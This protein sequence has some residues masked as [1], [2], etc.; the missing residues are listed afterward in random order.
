MRY[1]VYFEVGG[2]NYSCSLKYASVEIT[3]PIDQMRLRLKNKQKQLNP[4]EKMI[5]QR[6]IDAY[7]DAQNIELETVEEPGDSDKA[8]SN[9]VIIFII[10]IILGIIIAPILLTFAM[11]GKLLLKSTFKDILGFEE[12]KKFRKI[13]LALAYLWMV[14]CIVCFAVFSVLPIDVSN[15]TI[16]I[17]ALF[18]GNL[19]FVIIAVVKAKHIKKEYKEEVTRTLREDIDEKV[20]EYSTEEEVN[21]DPMEEAE[22]NQLSLE[23]VSEYIKNLDTLHKN[24]LINDDEY[25]KHKDFA[26]KAMLNSPEKPIPSSNVNKTPKP[27]PMQSASIKSNSVVIEES[28]KI[29]NDSDSPEKTRSLKTRKVVLGS[30]SLVLL[31]P[32]PVLSCI[33]P[34]VFCGDFDV[35][36]PFF[37]IRLALASV[38]LLLSI[39]HLVLLMR[40][41]VGKKPTRC[42]A[43]ACLVCSFATITCCGVSFIGCHIPPFFNL[44]ILFT[45]L[46]S[47]V[48][49]MLCL[50]TKETKK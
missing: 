23:K 49:L 40:K 27:V 1:D 39:I 28:A 11:F 9:W 8:N 48:L 37:V 7:P 18:F 43:I 3:M 14:I 17:Y 32:T 12:Y 5:V 15:S 42:V 29:E 45:V 10:A 31:I 46:V 41:K 47:I 36:P 20:E 30:F 50:F 33:I 38:S 24:G 25:A 6:I 19:A 35:L 4:F 22:P 21:C 16:P 13:H 44:I 26:L 2:Q 34:V